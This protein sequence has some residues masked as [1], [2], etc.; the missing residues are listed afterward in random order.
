[1]RAFVFAWFT[2][3]LLTSSAGAEEIKLDKEPWRRKGTTTWWFEENH[4][5]DD[6]QVGGRTALCFRAG[7]TKAQ[8]EAACLKL[9]RKSRHDPVDGHD[10]CPKFHSCSCTVYQESNP[11][12][13]DC[14]DATRTPEEGC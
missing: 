14:T 2:L 12:E 9:C 13:C 5:C 6:A 4:R 3:A 1:M 10:R 7:M 11:M 8:V